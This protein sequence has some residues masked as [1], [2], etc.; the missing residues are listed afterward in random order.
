MLEWIGLSSAAAWWIVIASAAMFFF[1]LIALP[2]LVVR[3]P[4]DYFAH[5]HRSSANWPRWLALLRWPWL[6]VKNLLGLGCLFFGV[7]MLVL[8]GQGV[9][10]LL[11]GIT[12]L[13]FPGKYK[14]QRW[15]VSRRGVLQTI[16]WL[17]ERADK[18]PLVLDR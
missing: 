3:I 10:T 2:S 17:R 11:L 9:L 12:L 4:A 15:V 14:L 16:N 7:L 13:D 18:E 8:P 5:P 6:I 1:A